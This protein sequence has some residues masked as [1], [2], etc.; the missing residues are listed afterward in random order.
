[1]TTTLTQTN[2]KSL[3]AK[4]D[5]GPFISLY[6]PIEQTRQST[7]NRLVLK[8]LQK[9]AAEQFTANYPALDW[10]K[11]DRQLDQ[12][13]EDLLA[14][15]SDLP[16]SFG[17]IVSATQQVVFPLKIDVEPQVNVADWPNLLPYIGTQQLAVNFDLLTLN[18]DSF[19]LYEVSEGEVHELELPGD[20]PTNLQ[21]ALGTEL[22]GGET[23]F[24]SFTNG[25]SGGVGVHG[26]NTLD[27]EKEIDHRNY[28]Q[29]VADYLNGL[30]AER[31]RAVILFALPENQSLFRQINK[32][33]YVSEQL[34]IQKSPLNLSLTQLESEIAPLQKQWQAGLVA[35]LQDRY[36]AAR[37]QQLALSD[38][39]EILEAARMGR[40]DTLLI[41]RSE[42]LTAPS[43]WL[44]E[45]SDQVLQYQGRVRILPEDDYP[46]TEP[47]VAI[48]RY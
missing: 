9:S 27:A 33:P 19:V 43:D 46:A 25:Q 17:V 29:A 12:L 40:I 22:S 39:T 7:K 45:L 42:V 23:N 41:S 38:R 5:Q 36:D 34:S 30:I 4:L 11:F 44:L 32:N 24:R 2:L 8:Q 13:P 28:Y 47:V 10:E 31:K 26:H 21:K 6:L 14:S 35:I 18:Q 3:L 15:D 48:A 37:S 1:M 20:A 16:Q